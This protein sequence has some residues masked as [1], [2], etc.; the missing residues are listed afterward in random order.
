MVWGHNEQHVESKVLAP[1]HLTMLLLISK[2][3]FWIMLIVTQ[4]LYYVDNDPINNLIDM[5]AL[6]Y[7]QYHAI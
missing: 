5:G 1:S 6:S 2:L 3:M 4:I 7:H